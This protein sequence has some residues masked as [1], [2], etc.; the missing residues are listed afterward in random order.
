VPFLPLLGFGAAIGGSVIKSSGGGLPSADGGAAPVAISAEDWRD[1][2]TAAAPEIDADFLLRWITIESGGNPCATGMANREAGIGQIDF[3]DGP[4]CNTTF[5]ELRA[6]CSGQRLTRG[7]TADERATQVSSFVALARQCLAAAR[8]NM[9]AAG[10]TWS[11]AETL[12]LAKMHHALPL[13]GRYLRVSRAPNWAAYKHD[14]MQLTI[15][16]ANGALPGL[17]RWV[18]EFPRLFRNPEKCI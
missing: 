4:A 1:E 3:G 9:A 12:R 16:T 8:G 2:V 15:S 7:L 13:L 11:N 18:S 5:A 17:G 6:Y 14:A 10:V